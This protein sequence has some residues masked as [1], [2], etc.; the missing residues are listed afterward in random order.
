[1][2]EIVQYYGLR[3]YSVFLL[4]PLLI[5]NRLVEARYPAF[6]LSSL[7]EGQGTGEAL[8]ELFLKGTTLGLLFFFLPNRQNLAPKE[9]LRRSV[10][11]GWLAW[12]ILFS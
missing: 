12:Y 10:S 8:L 4:Y 3:W 1:M 7:A 9:R 2:K 5:A 6:T 11:L